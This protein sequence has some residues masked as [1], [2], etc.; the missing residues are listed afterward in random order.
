MPLLKVQLNHPGKEKPFQIGKGYHTE[1]H[2][3]IREWNN[4]LKH[5]RKF[6]KCAGQFLTDVKSE[7][8]RAPLYFWGE[9][10]GHS[11]FNP[12]ES[13]KPNGIHEPFHSLE[14]VGRMNTD[15]YVYGAEF[16]YA[17][18]MQ[19]GK[20]KELSPNS[21]V[22]FGTRTHRGFELD[23]V[24]IVK[25][26]ET[27][28][29]V[30]NTSAVA[31]SDAY[32][33]Q[34]LARLDQTYLGPEYSTYKKIYRSLTWW[35]NPSYFSFVPSWL[36]YLKKQPSKVVLPIPP[37]SSQKV[38]HP[39]SHLDKYDHELLWTLVVTEVLKQGFCIGIRFT[40][41]TCIQ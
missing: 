31:Y 36:N 35:D 10:E 22:F 40:E 39:F 21:L 9:W 19:T 25:S 41:P 37:F 6:I 20:L 18:C 8:M 26:H 33:E 34:T 30:F 12:L 13:E 1:G 16:K 29:S 28:E 11:I 2:L 7:P 4:E 17:T 24:F 32:K 27:A 15:P 5:Y 23:T 3:V 14:N 38:G